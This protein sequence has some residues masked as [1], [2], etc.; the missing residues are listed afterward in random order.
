MLENPKS[1]SATAVKTEILMFP[2]PYSQEAIIEHSGYE[3]YSF[4]R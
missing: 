4:L 3:E 2:P 1:F